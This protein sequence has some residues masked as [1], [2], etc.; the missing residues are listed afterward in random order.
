[1][2]GRGVGRGVVQALAAAWLAGLA[3]DVARAHGRS[4]SLSSFEIE[5]GPPV[6]AE[7]RVRSPMTDLQ[8]V[9]PEIASLAPTRAG[10]GPEALGWIDR[11]LQEHVV[12][13]SGGEPCVVVGPA[14]PAVTSDPTHVGRAWRV[15]CERTGA[16]SIESTAFYEAVPGHLHL[17]RVR[18]AGS[19]PVEQVLVQ[20]RPRAPIEASGAA[21]PAAGSDLLDYA[22]LGV[23]H[24]F[25]GAD[26]VCFVL[27]LLLVGGTLGEVAAVVTGFTAAHSVTLALGVL[28][29]VRPGSATVQALI[30]LSIVIVAL[31]NFFETAGA[32]TRRLVRGSLVLLLAGAIGGAMVGR[33]SVPALA[34]V[35]IGVFSLCYFALL[36]RSARPMRLRWIVAFVFGLVHGLG[37]ASVL[38]DA[39]LEPGRLA[40]ALLGFNVGVELGQLAIVAALWPAYRLLLASGPRARPV[41]VQIGSAAVLAAGLFWFL[42]RAMGGA[43]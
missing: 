2:I 28:G 3:P 38:A 32:S 24:I 31:E 30:G 1:M 12:L 8:R 5:I 14:T 16:L 29:V 33:V 9:I 43:G 23:E 18:F 4:T 21:T 6:R 39:G 17:A 19:P 27:A 42:T 15:L 20:S 10:P 26:H 22:R 41:A 35:G 25:T 34:L 11:Y 13:R 37:F 7:I 36:A 40:H